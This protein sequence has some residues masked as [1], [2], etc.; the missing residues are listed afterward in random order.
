MVKKPRKRLAMYRTLPDGTVEKEYISY[1][2]PILAKVILFRDLNR[3]VCLGIIFVFQ[4]PIQK[5]EEVEKEVVIAKDKTAS[6]FKVTTH[7]INICNLFK[8]FTQVVRRTSQSNEQ[9]K[10]LTLAEKAR[11][12]RSR[13]E[14]VDVKANRAK[15]FETL[16]SRAQRK[17]SPSP[18]AARPRDERER[19]PQRK[20]GGPVFARL[21]PRF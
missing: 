7:I 15:R 18:E 13:E 1:D 17:R 14:E 12:M 21:G 19:S 4:V 20:A 2:D 8:S 11:E 5:R 3:K 6:N 10:S 9:G 16:A